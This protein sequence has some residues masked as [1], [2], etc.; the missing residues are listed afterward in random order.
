MNNGNSY[1]GYIGKED[2]VYN[3]N[4]FMSFQPIN[5][6]DNPNSFCEL[7]K[8]Q[9]Y[10][11]WFVVKALKQEYRNK[12]QYQEFLKKEFL[13]MSNLE[14][15]NIVKVLSYEN[16][17][18]I[19][20]CIVMEFIDGITLS[21]FLNK[22]ISYSIKKKI[23]NELLSAL[24]YIHSKQVIHRDLKP[25]NILIT[26]NG[27]NLKLIDFGLSDTDD[28]AVLKQPA[29]TRRYAANEQLIP[30]SKIDNRADIYALGF[31]INDIFKGKKYCNIIKKCEQKEKED[32]Y[33]NVEEIIKKINDNNKKKFI[34][35]SICL[36]I[37]IALIMVFI[38]INNNKTKLTN[39]IIGNN[40]L[41]NE[42]QTVKIL[43]N[44]NT[45]IDSTINKITTKHSK[46]NLPIINIDKKIIN[47][48]ISNMIYV[49]G[50]SFNIGATE[51][52]GDDFYSW[53]KPVHKV[54]LSPFHIS[55]YEVTQKQWKTIMG[56]NPSNFV[57]DNL[58]V[59]NITFAEIQEFIRRLN[60][61]T[62]KH[63]SLPTDAQWEFAARGG[64]KTK[65]N[66]FAGSNSAND[67]S[68][69]E[70]NSNNTTHKVGTKKPNELGIY[71]MSGNV[72]EFCNDFETPYSNSP[73]M[74][75]K[76]MSSGSRHVV[77]GGGFSHP[78]NNQRVSCK[79]FID[80]KKSSKNIG[81]RLVLQ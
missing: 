69:N 37:I 43:S 50:G 4:D 33:N 60:Q 65:R 26:Y 1:S 64:T 11:K 21:E 62:G 51:E 25:D 76:G 81:F 28:F 39:T 6:K 70:N 5:R 31:I 7:F 78:E 56:N 35:L 67:V 79:F 29:G 27:N 47:E 41:N 54:T 42:K 72:W 2:I 10:S 12:I 53:E 18:D 32:R 48:I 24:S 8:A 59:E 30:N 17:K 34:Y 19:G 15:N 23:L 40:K 38:T 49:Y 61:K 45:K 46:Q 63:F 52:Q 77:R 14:H 16:N 57:G 3:I 75:P 74:N 44:D 58:P 68:W 71:D 73:Q 66:K 20:Y 80:T 13:I 55:K 22:D 9:R 36:I